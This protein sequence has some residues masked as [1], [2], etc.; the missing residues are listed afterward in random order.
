L[1]EEQ[2]TEVPDFLSKN[3]L[4][5]MST[6]L[7]FVIISIFIF[8]L[9][10]L[11]IPIKIVRLVNRVKN[12][13][14]REQKTQ[15]TYLLWGFIL[16]LVGGIISDVL[17]QIMQI[18]G[19]GL[20]IWIFLRGESFLFIAHRLDNLI[21]MSKHGTVAYNYKFPGSNIKTD[22]QLLGGIV[23]ALTS[24][25][26]EVTGSQELVKEIHL[27]DVNLSF[28]SVSNNA[29]VLLISQRTSRFIN[30]TLDRFTTEFQQI[31][32][33]KVE[34]LEIVDTKQ[35]KTVPDLIEK[36]FLVKGSNRRSHSV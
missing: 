24:S 25:L 30:K 29:L 13:V 16:S 1:E 6:I 22:E 31:Y 23:S 4:F 8:L 19:H 7:I 32:G 3:E 12:R 20:I 34:T 10:A 33:K 21:I 17:G 35:F 18:A 28:R 14:P 5:I 9:Y 11:I 26:Q 15:F 2:F 27:G 36:I